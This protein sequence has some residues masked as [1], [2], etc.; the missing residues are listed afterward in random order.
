MPSKVTFTSAE[1]LKFS[2]DRKGVKATFEFPLNQKS[3]SAMGWGDLAEFQH[4]SDLDGDLAASIIEMIPN[5][6]GNKRHRMQLDVQRINKFVGTRRELE[7]KKSKGTRWTVQ[8]VAIITDMNGCKKMESYM[9]SCAKSEMRISYEK[10]PEQTDLPG[11]E[12]DNNQES[13]GVN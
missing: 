8:C 2:K 3:S 5:E 13:L 12:V 9:A 1:L 10:Q 7:G 11:V 6:E 4:G